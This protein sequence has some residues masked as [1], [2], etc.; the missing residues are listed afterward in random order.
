MIMSSLI[1][2]RE[3]LSFSFQVVLKVCLCLRLISL[4][5]VFFVVMLFV[6]SAA[7]AFSAV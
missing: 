6:F 5:F 1:F 2:I 4:F 7:L 3:L